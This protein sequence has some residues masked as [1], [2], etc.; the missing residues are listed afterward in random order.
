MTLDLRGLLDVFRGGLS[1]YG[2]LMMLVASTKLH[3][4]MQPQN[5]SQQLLHFLKFYSTLDMEKNWISIDPP[6]L[7]DKVTEA[8]VLSRRSLDDPA[9]RESASGSPFTFTSQPQR[10]RISRVGQLNPKHPFLLS[11]QDPADPDNDLGRKAYGFSHISA[12]FATLHHDLQLALSKT[13]DE[14]KNNY[15]SLLAR[16]IGSCPAVVRQ[17]RMKLEAYG[18]YL[19]EAQGASVYVPRAQR[20][21]APSE[22]AR[23]PGVN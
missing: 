3:G 10:K 11:L 8:E 23:H 22:Q 17:R 20:P 2:L 21:I 14:K 6:A 7:R 1:S 13:M 18:R 12:T 4:N 15:D 16:L 9:S 19:L 5:P